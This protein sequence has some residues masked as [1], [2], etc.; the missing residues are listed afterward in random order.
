MWQAPDLQLFLNGSMVGKT[1]FNT[2]QA[3][4]LVRVLDSSKKLT[5]Q[6]KD[7]DAAKAADVLGRTRQCA[8]ASPVPCILGPV[9]L[10]LSRVTFT[11]TTC[12]H[13]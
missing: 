9:G 12:A 5:I 10:E 6:V 2:Y 8:P 11:P 13:Q 7:F 1:A 4:F 3:S